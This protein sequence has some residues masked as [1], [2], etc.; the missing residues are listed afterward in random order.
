MRNPYIPTRDYLKH[1]KVLRYYTLRRY[2]IT[3]ADLDMMLFLY[4][5]RFFSSSDFESYENIFVWNRQ[6]LDKLKRDGWVV[7][8]RARKK[9]KKALYELSHKG[10]KAITSLYEKLEGGTIPES[11]YANPM[12]RTDASFSDRTH[13]M[14]IIKINKEIRKKKFDL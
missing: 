6:R 2:G 13:R 1:W 14:E 3:T 8:F 10:K 9:N 5:E 11:R 12:F 4:S 7:L